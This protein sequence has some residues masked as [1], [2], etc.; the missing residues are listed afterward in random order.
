MLALAARTTANCG[1]EGL[2]RLSYTMLHG[3]VEHLD[4]E[5]PA[6]LRPCDGDLR[7][8]ELT[9]AKLPCLLVQASE[10]LLQRPL[11]AIGDCG[12]QR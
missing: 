9:Q 12:P 4:Q 5:G 2:E 3:Q 10:K 11:V 7:G 1:D 8:E 6:D